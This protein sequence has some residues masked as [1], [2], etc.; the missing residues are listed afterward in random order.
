[1]SLLDNLN[2]VLKQ[3]FGGQ[4]DDRAG[5]AQLDGRFGRQGQLEGQ[6][7]RQGQLGS[8]PETSGGGFGNIF[9]QILGGLTGGGSG[10]VLGT[11]ALGGLVGALLGN[12]GVKGAAGGAILA[13]GIQLW[14]QYRK[15]LQEESARSDSGP[16]YQQPPAFQPTEDNAS[17]SPASPVSDDQISRIIR[18]LVYAAK[19]DGRVDS[20]E[21]KR[22]WKK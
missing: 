5:Q 19:S 18:A 15:R 2:A 7:G 13:G 1:M 11:S 17:A 22:L 16:I 3:E 4:A 14:N 6:L 20:G 9:G 12:K 10:S 21:K 8:Q